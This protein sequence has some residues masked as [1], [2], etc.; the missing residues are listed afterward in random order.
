[1]PRLSSSPRRVN[2]GRAYSSSPVLSF[3][4]SYFVLFYRECIVVH[5]CRLAPSMIIICLVICKIDL[6]VT[7]CVI[8]LFGPYV[9]RNGP[10]KFLIATVSNIELL[11]CLRKVWQRRC[12]DDFNKGS[13]NLKSTTRSIGCSSHRPSLLQCK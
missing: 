9:N 11:T 2:N 6:F 5:C 12:E 4:L 13:C 7:G 1:M 10:G 8:Y 3:I